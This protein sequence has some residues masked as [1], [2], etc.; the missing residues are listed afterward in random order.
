[1]GRK[2]IDKD[3]NHAGKVRLSFYASQTVLD[4]LEQAKI[5]EH[6]N[7]TTD[8]LTQIILEYANH[9]ILKD[10]SNDVQRTSGA[11]ADMMKNVLSEQDV[12]KERLSLL[13]SKFALL[14]RNVDEL[15]DI[16]TDETSLKSA[17]SS[18]KK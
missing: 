12:L 8:V 9:K 1:M 13:E 7:S 16:L 6:T 3:E 2:R 11:S 4:I 10:I 14:H 5:E 18:K 15:L 17:K